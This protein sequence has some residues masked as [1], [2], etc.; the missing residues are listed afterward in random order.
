[1]PQT[2]WTTDPDLHTSTCAPDRPLPPA[3]HAGPSP[4][5]ANAQANDNCPDQSP[6][7]PHAGNVST[8][9]APQPGPLRPHQTPS[10][11][12]RAPEK[13]S[14]FNI[15][16]APTASLH[17][18]PTTTRPQLSVKLSL[19]PS[20]HDTASPPFPTQN[21]RPPFLT[22]NP[23]PASGCQPSHILLRDTRSRDTTNASRF[24]HSSPPRPSLPH[25][26]WPHPSWPHPSWP[27]PSTAASMRS[28]IGPRPT[29]TRRVLHMPPTRPH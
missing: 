14:G 4:P 10:H 2:A 9:H 27:K 22:L 21:S 8:R 5:P 7:E 6:Q 11:P 29:Q 28:H 18:Q 12:H 24:P 3:P 1:M 23:A 25:P 20:R 17:Q 13:T 15:P 16:N 19:L 26:S